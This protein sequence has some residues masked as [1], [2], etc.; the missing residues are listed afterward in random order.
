MSTLGFAALSANL[1][2]PKHRACSE[3]I[4]C[5]STGSVV[6]RVTTRLRATIGGIFAPSVMLP[7]CTPAGSAMFMLDFAALSA[8]LPAQ[9]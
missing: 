1:Q 4:I 2:N 6:G 8:N 7:P 9:D 5:H 3:R